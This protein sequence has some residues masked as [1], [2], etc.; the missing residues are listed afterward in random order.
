MQMEKGKECL[1]Q[2]FGCV[3]RTFKLLTDSI[4]YTGLQEEK[5]EE[6]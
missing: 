3:P 6:M 2:N 5:E 1:K 4:V